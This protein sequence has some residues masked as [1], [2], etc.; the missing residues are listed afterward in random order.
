GQLPAAAAGDPP[1]V[2][3]P[4]QEGG[5]MSSLPFA[6]ATDVVTLTIS[7]D[8]TELPRT[9]PMLGVEVLSQANRIPYARLRIG[10]GDSARGDFA[11]SSGDL[12]VPGGSLSIKAGYHGK[13]EP[14][15]SGVVLTQRIVVRRGSSWLEVEARDGARARRRHR[16]ANANGRRAGA[17]VGSLGTV[18]AR[19]VRDRSPVER[20]REPERGHIER[21]RG[22]QRGSPLARRRAGVGRTAVDRGRRD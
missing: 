6:A 15:F 20:Q 14:I 19:R 16:R 18:P 8:G 2:S 11:R 12:F 22:P 9:V 3:T 21:R 5:V 13:V 17:R 4:R 1:D 10:D 7:V